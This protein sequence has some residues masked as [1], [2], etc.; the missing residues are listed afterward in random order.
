MSETSTT[1]RG[2][3]RKSKSRN[4]MSETRNQKSGPGVVTRTDRNKKLQ[5]E[6][7]NEGCALCEHIWKVQFDT[8]AQLQFSVGKEDESYLEA[9]DLYA[10]CN[11]HL[12]MFNRIT[13]AGIS[14]K[15][16][17]YLIQKSLDGNVFREY[18]RVCPVCEHLESV[19]REEVRKIAEVP[20]EHSSGDFVCLDHLKKILA[21]TCP[22]NRG[23]VLK[24][25]KES[26]NTLFG[27]LKLLET[28][29]YYQVSTR[30]KSSLWRTVEK[31]TGRK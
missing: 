26:L 27:Q 29:N 31:L 4:Q 12:R 3:E 2:S 25:Y 28:E 14:S 16:L 19:E 11:K 15:M 24:A 17:R 30:V 7:V 22:E 1:T 8:L 20:F 23:N 5:D 13:S 18:V 6:T 9:N 10:I 21:A